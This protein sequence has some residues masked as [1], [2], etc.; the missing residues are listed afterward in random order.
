MCRTLAVA[1]TR[2]RGRLTSEDLSA[3]WRP[4]AASRAGLSPRSKPESASEHRLYP[5]CD[6]LTYVTI[7][8]SSSL[9]P[10]AKFVSKILFAR[11]PFTTHDQLHLHG[12]EPVHRTLL[13]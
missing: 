7:V 9:Q 6:E 4:V 3:D 5:S 10:N 8:T 1:Y 11:V 13:R 2:D 12:I